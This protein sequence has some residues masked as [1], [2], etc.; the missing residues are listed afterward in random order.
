[1]SET[2]GNSGPSPEVVSDLAPSGTLRATINMANFLLVTGQTRSGEPEGVSPDMAGELARQLGVRLELLPYG[3]PGEIA[4]DAG[5]G[6]WDIANIGAEPKRAEKIDF[7][8]AYCEI[9]ATYLVSAGSQIRTIEDVDRPGVRV[10]V[11]ARSAYDLWLDRHVRHA[12]LVRADGLDASFELFIHERLDAMAVLRP[13]LISD[14][15][16]L[17]GARILDGQFTAVQQ[18]M[19]CAR[20]RHAGAA[21]LRNFVEAMKASDFVADLITK[22]GVQGRLS[23]APAAQ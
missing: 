5:T 9:Q 20:G 4:D 16:K 13:R 10:A 22:H 12:E 19:G 21:F 8:A 14:A 3:T 15:E 2:S 1:M 6:A 23:V 7:T 17:P 11:S 18:A